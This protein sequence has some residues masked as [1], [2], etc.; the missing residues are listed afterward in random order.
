MFSSLKYIDLYKANDSTYGYNI[1]DGGS[2]I[3][4]NASSIAIL[5]VTIFGIS[6]YIKPKKRNDFSK[7]YRQEETVQKLKKYNMFHHMCLEFYKN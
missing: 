5:S 6:F 2:T 1:T 7:P 4:S 3:S